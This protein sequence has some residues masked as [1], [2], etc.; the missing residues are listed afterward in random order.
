MMIP[1]GP[2]L[3]HLPSLHSSPHILQVT[4]WWS[5][6]EREDEKSDLKVLV[7][8]P[9]DKY[10]HNYQQI[11]SPQTSWA[12]YLLSLKGDWSIKSNTQRLVLTS[13]TECY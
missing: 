1:N 9:I 5:A 10:T 11:K 4:F 3:K 6:S 7:K 13:E 8:N 12:E 2:S